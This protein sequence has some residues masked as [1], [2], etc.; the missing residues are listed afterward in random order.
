MHVPTIEAPVHVYNMGG[1]VVDT[2]H[3]APNQGGSIVVIDEDGY[4]A[5]IRMYNQSAD[6]SRYRVRV[7]RAAS[8]ASE[9]NPMY[10]RLLEFVDPE[11][12]P[13]SDFSKEVAE[14][15]EDRRRNLKKIIRRVE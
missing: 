15:V 11:Q 4:A 7:M 3:T 6:P 14:A 2:I 5:S 13:W 9:P 1:W 8:E 12:P 10:D